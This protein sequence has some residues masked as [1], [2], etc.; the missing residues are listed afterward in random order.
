[1]LLESERQASAAAFQSELRRVEMEMEAEPQTVL[2]SLFKILDR[3]AAGGS[4]STARRK[5]ALLRLGSIAAHPEQVALY[6]AAASHASTVC[7]VGFNAGH[8]AAV[9]MLANPSLKLHTFDLFATRASVA[10][11][12]HLQQRFPGRLFAHRGDSLSTL[13]S[14][15]LQPL[16]DLIHVDGRHSYLNVVADAL[17]SLRIAV[18]SAVWLF[19]DQ[20]DPSQCDA[21]STVA[22]E[23]T[24]ATCDLMRSRVMQPHP[25]LLPNGSAIARVGKRRVA[26]MVRGARAKTLEG[27][28]SHAHNGG[29]QPIIARGRAS[30][31]MLRRHNSSNVPPP[32]SLACVPLCNVRWTTAAAERK[33]ASYLEAT[34]REAEMW[35][36]ALRPQGCV[37]S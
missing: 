14:A 2:T 12:R 25:T 7:E 32:G 6:S 28:Q 1:M 26:A 15:K 33:W 3:L 19:D 29:R 10:A 5:A 16:C 34:K 18:P 23:P 30:S 21:E 20:C 36:A 24:L 37:Y 31:S 8:S 17:H 13:P 35:Q 27:R 11:L 22:G 9:W 4:S